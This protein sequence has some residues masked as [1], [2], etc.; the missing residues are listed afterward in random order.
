[1]VRLSA[2]AIAVTCS[3]KSGGREMVNC[4]V[5]RS[6]R[7]HYIV[8][9]CN[10]SV[11]GRDLPPLPQPGKAIGP[12]LFRLRQVLGYTGFGA[13]MKSRDLVGCG[14]WGERG[15]VVRPV[16]VHQPHIH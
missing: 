6:M 11:W 14:L 1:M 7:S 13:G 3:A 15:P 12:M 9:K 5:V 4:L 2:F 16:E 8:M 10:A